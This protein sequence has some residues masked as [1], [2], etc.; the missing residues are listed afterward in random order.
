MF[1]RAL[2]EILQISLCFKFETVIGS[3]IG[4]NKIADE[5]GEESE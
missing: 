4:F 3:N 1:G 2:L 5:A